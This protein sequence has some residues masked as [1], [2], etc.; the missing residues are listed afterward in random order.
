MT[1]QLKVAKSNSMKITRPNKA[2]N[3]NLS[4]LK[5]STILGNKKSTHFDKS[6]NT[7]GRVSIASTHVKD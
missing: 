6:S 7:E 4:K 3:L 1:V 2:S 5:I